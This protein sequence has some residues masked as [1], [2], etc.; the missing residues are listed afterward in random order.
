MHIFFSA[1]EVRPTALLTHISLSLLT[2]ITQTIMDNSTVNALNKTLT[3]ALTL[4]ER[5]ITV[6]SM[7]VD[8]EDLAAP[9]PIGLYATLKLEEAIISYRRT[10]DEQGVAP[11]CLFI[12]SDGPEY[13]TLTVGDLNS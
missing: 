6:Q 10:L 2:N 13:G 4:I 3:E 12:S 11:G 5:S 9:C 1:S 8:M 7:E